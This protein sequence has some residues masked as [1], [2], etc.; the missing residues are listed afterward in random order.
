MFYGTGAK[1]SKKFT[2]DLSSF[3]TS[4]VTDMSFMFAARNR[5]KKQKFQ[6]VFFSML[7]EVDLSSFNTGNVQKFDN[8]FS[9]CNKLQKIYISDNFIIG[10]AA[11]SANMYNACNA[12]LTSKP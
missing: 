4:K 8:M 10:G 7:E 11:T 2:L 6:I 1:A 5:T 12:E 9:G 3:N